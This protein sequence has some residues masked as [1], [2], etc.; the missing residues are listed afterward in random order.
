MGQ[1]KA[2]RAAGAVDTGQPLRTSTQL[3]REESVNLSMDM[4]QNKSV[5][6]EEGRS[7]HTSAKSRKRLRR[8][9]LEPSSLGEEHMQCKI[10]RL[11]DGQ[12][13][14]M[15]DLYAEMHSLLAAAKKLYA[16]VEKAYQ[17]KPS[18]VLVAKNLLLQAGGYC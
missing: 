6:G 17:L 9:C 12:H 11:E 15:P 1:A 8:E 3:A 16:E 10:L 2:E 13:E 14:K 5:D 4:A 18:I 7:Q